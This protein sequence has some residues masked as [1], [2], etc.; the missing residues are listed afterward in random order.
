MRSNPTCL[1]QKAIQNNQNW[2]D[3]NYGVE[4]VKT[5]EAFLGCDKSMRV[6]SESEVFSRSLDTST[7][8]LFTSL[9]LMRLL[10]CLT[11]G[12]I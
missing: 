3:V 11:F 6:T 10:L 2:T 5:N 12:N 8:C 9:F 1:S 7:Y 4:C